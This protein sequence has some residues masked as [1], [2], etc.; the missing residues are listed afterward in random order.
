[1]RAHKSHLPLHPA[2]A[3]PVQCSC[4]HAVVGV[5]QRPSR[6][7]LVVDR[8]QALQF[9][10]LR[11]GKFTGHWTA[12]EVRKPKASSR[13]AKSATKSPRPPA[14][15]HLRTRRSRK[16]RRRHPS[17]ARPYQHEARALAVDV[18]R[19]LADGPE[20]R[21]ALASS[22][23]N[24]VSNKVFIRRPTQHGSCADAAVTA[25]MREGPVSGR[26]ALDGSP[27]GEAA[28]L[29]GGRLSYS[30]RRPGVGGLTL[31]GSGFPSPTGDAA[32]ELS[33]VDPH[34]LGSA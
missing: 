27:G 25:G 12:C 18:Q 11:Q 4:G 32:Y 33:V 31:S 34:D 9:E 21:P 15:P 7:D 29:G 14:S 17:G 6:P 20:L 26:R 30:G 8:R 13:S 28:L 10:R 16:G 3:L 1:M 19:A 23:N 24:S 5:L 22:I 2:V